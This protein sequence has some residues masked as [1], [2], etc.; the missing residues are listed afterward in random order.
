M[1]N[2]ARMTQINYQI[3]LAKPITAYY[4]HKYPALILSNRS[5]KTNSREWFSFQIDPSRQYNIGDIVDNDR[6]VVSVVEAII[7]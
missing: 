1:I 6:T 5:K 7:F 2:D 3:E 4:Q